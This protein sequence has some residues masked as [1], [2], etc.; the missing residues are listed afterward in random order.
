MDRRFAVFDMTVDVFHH[1]DCVVH[2][3]PDCQD[4][5]KQGK[6][7]DA[8]AKHCHERCCTEHRQR[9]SDHRNDH[10]SCRTQAE[11]N[12]H[13]HNHD[14]LDQGADHFIDRCTDKTC[15]LEGNGDLHVWRQVGP[16]TGQQL[17]ELFDDDQRIGIGR[18]VQPEEY[19]FDSV[20]ACT[21]VRRCCT[22]FDLGDI[23]QAHD[24]GRGGLD[25][26]FA[27]LCDVDQVRVDL[28]IRHHIQAFGLAGRRRN[29]VIAQRLSNVAAGNAVSGHAISIE[30]DA[31]RHLLPTVEV[32]TAD[33]FD[34]RKLGLHHPLQIVRQGSRR[35]R[36]AGKTNIC[37][38]SCVTRGFH[39]H[40]VIGFGGQPIFDF[41]DLGHDL[42]H[43]F[44]GVGVE[45]HAH[46]DDA[47][48]L[49]RGRGHV[50]DVLDRGHR[51]GNR[52]GHKPLH[53]LWCS[54]RVLGGN[55]QCRALSER[56]LANRKFL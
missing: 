12:D 1:D 43:R 32:D 4:H 34:R 8:E 24:P 17:V 15:E 51:L 2:D 31:H 40:R 10:R 9:D 5:G 46:C 28:D 26:H 47:L 52:L 39:D 16:D 35:H 19:G 20:H 45:L 11:E 54:A 6:Q 30:P 21:G 48:A 36:R 3:Q 7:V 18:S 55:R 23:I 33:A 41:I 25:H 44:V 22:Q 29:V 38:S 53:Q 49:G 42:G 13:H 50:V 14:R 37:H 27:K 56:I